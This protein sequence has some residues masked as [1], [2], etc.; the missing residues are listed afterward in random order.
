MDNKGKKLKWIVL[1]IAVILII[2]IL[3][4]GNSESKKGQTPDSKPEVS[5]SSISESAESQESKVQTES[6]SENSQKE[7][8]TPAEE[9]SPESEPEVTEAPK[10][11]YYVGDAVQD[12][13]MR[14]VYMA[15]GDYVS[16]NEFLQPKDG[17]KYIFLK[18]AFEN[19]SD[20][21]DASVSFYSFE[22]YADGYNAEMYYGGEENLSATLSAGRSTTGNIYFE[23]PVDATEIEVEYSTNLFTSDKIKFIFEGTKDSGYTP[24]VNTSSAADLYNAGDT[25]ETDNLKITYLS[26]DEYISDNEFIQPK[27]GFHYIT[28]AF[29]F[30]NTGTSDESV[31]EFS[32]DC[33]ADG[34]AMEG[35]YLENG[36]NAKISAGRKASGNVTFEVPVDADTVEVEYVTNMWTSDRIVF[37]A[38]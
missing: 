20:K 12:G 3:G 17:Y 27:D 22:C 23:V 8:T 9:S 28:C 21:K 36:L 30:E 4:S 6:G 26:C 31:S 35:V 1:A 14:I 2:G 15:S 38:R 25:V 34:A 5:E 7:E 18:F 24:T 33:Y 32:F 10:E 19:T 37:N 11:A 29:E 16:D 13:D